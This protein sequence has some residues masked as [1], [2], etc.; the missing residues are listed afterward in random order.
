MVTM[1]LMY[2]DATTEINADDLYIG[3]VLID[4]FGIACHSFL[5]YKLVIG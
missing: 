1:F 2:L 4:I 5:I 3:T